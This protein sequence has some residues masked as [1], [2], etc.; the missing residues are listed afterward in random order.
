MLLEP[1]VGY[2]WHLDLSNEQTTLLNQQLRYQKVT[3]FESLT[4]VHFK[5]SLPC[6]SSENSIKYCMVS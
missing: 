6:T 2:W 4:K 1:W 5:T 3:V